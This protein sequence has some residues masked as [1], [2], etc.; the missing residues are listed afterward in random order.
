MLIFFIEQMMVLL[1]ECGLCFRTAACMEGNYLSNPFFQNLTHM[2]GSKFNMWFLKKEMNVN[3]LLIHD[4]AHLN[5]K[6]RWFLFD[7]SI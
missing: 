5:L 2:F 3:N 7:S 4:P 1:D 6:S